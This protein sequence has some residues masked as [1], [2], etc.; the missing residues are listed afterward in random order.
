MVT[1]DSQ[2]PSRVLANYISN[3]LGVRI[4][5]AG[6]I[7]YDPIVRTAL[8]EKNLS[9]LQWQES[10]ILKEVDSIVRKLTSSTQTYGTKA[11][12]KN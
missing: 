2:V 11:I 12:S 3:E 5:V 10:P 7:K 4:E 1:A 9:I 6:K 8:R